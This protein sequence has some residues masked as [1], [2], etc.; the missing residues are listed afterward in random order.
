[1]ETCIFWTAVIL[2]IL[3]QGPVSGAVA[4]T[5]RLTTTV[6]PPVKPFLSVSWSFR[7]ANVITSTSKNVT[8]PQYAGRIFLD[9]ATGSLELR[10]LGL[11]DSGEYTV[12]IIPDGGLQQQGKT[13]LNVYTLISGAS[14][15]SPSAVLIE[16]KSSTNLTCEASGNISSTVW[17]KD[18]R[19]LGPTDR[20]TFSED[21]GTVFL[22]PVH[23]SHH[24][25]YQC[26]VSNPI[27]SVTVEHDLV[28]NFGPHNLSIVG[29]SPVSP[30]PGVALQC[31]AASVPP[32][33]FSWTFNGNETHVNSSL[34]IIERVVHCSL[35]VILHAARCS[36]PQRPD[37]TRGGRS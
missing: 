30:G 2:G 7:E 36:D 28:V 32:A 29:P 13:I 5:V 17:M 6:T 31:I 14:I 21:N 15:S 3:P 25:A 24:G 9:R 10:N 33:N 12:N 35:L 34:Y 27:S 4:G 20:V 23:S 26:R 37:V 18:G 16:D 11:E 22:H 1:M 8:G 19:P